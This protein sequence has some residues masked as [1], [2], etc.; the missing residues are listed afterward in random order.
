MYPTCL[1]TIAVVH[2]DLVH[3]F[4]FLLPGAILGIMMRTQA[5]LVELDVPHVFVPWSGGALKTADF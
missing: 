2:Q 1:F 3:V 5:W 4:V